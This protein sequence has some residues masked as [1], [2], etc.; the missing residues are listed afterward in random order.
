V[1]LSP[2]PPPVVIDLAPREAVEKFHVQRLDRAAFVSN[3]TST[4]ASLFQSSQFFQVTSLDFLLSQWRQEN[5]LRKKST[6]TSGPSDQ[7]AHLVL[8][9]T[10]TTSPSHCLCSKLL[11]ILLFT[12]SDP[13]P[14]KSAQLH[15]SRL[16]PNTTRWCYRR[17]PTVSLLSSR[18]CRTTTRLLLLSSLLVSPSHQD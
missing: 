13:R 11:M 18:H 3:L 17:S 16:N 14:S 4:E 1:S 15:C 2:L 10:P 8:L 6:E 9:T 12:T 7:T 5:P